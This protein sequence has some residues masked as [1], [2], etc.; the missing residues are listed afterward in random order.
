MGLDRPVWGVLTPASEYSEEH[1][2][3]WQRLTVVWIELTLILGTELLQGL[4]FVTR[5]NQ[6][7]EGHRSIRTWRLCA[8]CHVH[9][10]PPPPRQSTAP[11]ADLTVRP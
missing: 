5:S 10:G 1:S 11:V 4:K 2:I 9:P 3:L 7:Q 6:R 8:G